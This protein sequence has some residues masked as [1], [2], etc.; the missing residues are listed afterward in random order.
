MPKGDS[1]S[2]SGSDVVERRA[3]GPRQRKQNVNV[4]QRV[5]GHQPAANPERQILQHVGQ[6]V[7]GPQPDQPRKANS[8]PRI[9]QLK[10]GDQLVPTRAFAIGDNVFIKY[11]DTGNIEPG[12][13]LA[14]AKQ[15]N[16]YFKVSIG[17]ETSDHTVMVQK[18]E[19]FYEDDIPKAE[20]IKKKKG[21]ALPPWNKGLGKEHLEALLWDPNSFVHDKMLSVEEVHNKEL[22]FRQYPFD[23]FERNFKNAKS[24]FESNIE[25]ARLDLLA[26]EHDRIL[27]PRPARTIRKNP[28][29]DTHS[30]KQLLE[31]DLKAGLYLGMKPIEIRMQRS[32][33]QDFDKSCFSKHIFHTKQKLLEEVGWQFRRNR[34]AFAEHV[35]ESA[36]ENDTTERAE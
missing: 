30:A 11:S 29:W 15:G 21:A 2:Q 32:E 20:T 23:V 28:F 34:S 26:L 19:I 3:N 16:P 14:I 13:I 8:S 36:A 22:L 4:G 27:H 12:R 10:S 5:N 35:K 24:R 18:R 25:L 9:A 1:H 6:R 33:F 17:N 31:Q 7:N